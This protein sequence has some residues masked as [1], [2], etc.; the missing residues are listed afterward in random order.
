MAKL[1][2]CPF[3]GSKVTMTY[4]SYD[5]MYHVYHRGDIVMCA[6]KEPIDIDGYF[7]KSLTEAEDVWNRRVDN[8]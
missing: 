3:C 1:K 4:S 5:N 6:M 7:A 2:P 8:G